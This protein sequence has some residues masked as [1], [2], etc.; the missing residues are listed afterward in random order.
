MTLDELK[1]EHEKQN[2]SEC[3]VHRSAG[4]VAF[5]ERLGDYFVRYE[6]ETVPQLID[7]MSEIRERQRRITAARSAPPPEAKNDA[8]EPFTAQGQPRPA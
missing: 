6:A 3:V 7:L 5:E 1:A 4:L 2:G 8:P